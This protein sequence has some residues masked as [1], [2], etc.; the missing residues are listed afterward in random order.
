[1]K[2]LKDKNP[3]K[4]VLIADE[5]HENGSTSKV[6]ECDK[7]SYAS[8]TER[9][10]EQHIKDKHKES[11]NSYKT[12]KNNDKIP[13]QFCDKICANA[14]DFFSHMENHHTKQKSNKFKCDKCDF[15]TQTVAKLYEHEESKHVMM[16]T[17]FQ[18]K[19]KKTGKKDKGIQCDECKSTYKTASEYV[20]HNEKY[21]EN[22][23]LS[24]CDIFGF[25]TS[26]TESLK[27][28][29][30]SRNTENTKSQP[31]QNAFISNLCVYQGRDE[32]NLRRHM[33]D[34]HQGP[35]ISYK[36]PL[37]RI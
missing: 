21:H 36:T 31:K 19:K 22:K 32:D 18:E 30:H 11:K 16:T 20:K 17:K 23:Q 13:C 9:N 4:I 1:M 29:I 7:C 12:S 2:D 8:S 3:E 15:E 14:K 10:L 6:Y 25:R 28:H 27:R 24:D 34:H 33:Y 35:N 37:Q 5:E 26:D